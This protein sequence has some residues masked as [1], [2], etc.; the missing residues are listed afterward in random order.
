MKQT[1]N[2]PNH[3]CVYEV[4]LDNLT[5]LRI[6]K[7]YLD[8][9]LQREVKYENLPEDIQEVIGERIRELNE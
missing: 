5:I 6:V 9:P 7:D 1:F 3:D 8:S 2:I 4:T